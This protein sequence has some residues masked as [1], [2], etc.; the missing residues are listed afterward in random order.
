MICMSTRCKGNNSV[1]TDGKGRQHVFKI[2]FLGI[3]SAGK[4]LKIVTHP[5]YRR[6]QKITKKKYIVF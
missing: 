5:V 2:N 4:N 1:K 6:D 3:N